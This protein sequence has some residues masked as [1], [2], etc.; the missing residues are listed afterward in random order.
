[1][2]KQIFLIIFLLLH[3]YI[4]AQDGD[5]WSIQ[6]DGSIRWKIEQ[7][8]I[9]HADHLEM[10]GQMLSVVLRYGVDAE[11]AFHLNRSLVFPMLRMKP[12]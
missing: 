7:G 11:G 9:P 4:F 1:M 6:Q 2:K 5:R 8:N 12:K 10:S 3:T